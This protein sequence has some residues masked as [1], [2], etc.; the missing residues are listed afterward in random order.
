[1]YYSKHRL[2][3]DPEKQ[4]NLPDRVFFGFGACHILA[5][6]FLA[7][8][9][10]DDFYGEW[11]EPGEGFCGSHVIATNG[12]WAFDFHG[13]SNREKLLA[14]CWQRNRKQCLDW[15]ATI[16]KVE[17]SLLDTVE[18][19]KRNHRG[20]DQYFKNPIDRARQFVRSIKISDVLDNC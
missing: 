16:E 13:F 4:W 15:N 6:V 1:M 11:I 14:R 17:F 8:Y 7:E 12:V 10:T 2:K 20:P 3:C 5:G 19:N 18:L 9:A